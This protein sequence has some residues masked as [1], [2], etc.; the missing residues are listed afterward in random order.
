MENEKFNLET[1]EEL[2]GYKVW[3]VINMC[4]DYERMA[5]ALEEI[6]ND[7]EYLR[8]W[9]QGRKDTLRARGIKEELI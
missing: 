1:C 7:G 6:S 5:K 8:G 3:E 2:T 9:K 4:K